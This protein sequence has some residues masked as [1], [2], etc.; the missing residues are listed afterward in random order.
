MQNKTKLI[1]S[2]TLIITIGVVYAKPKLFNFNQSSNSKQSEVI[3]MNKSMYIKQIY[4]YDKNPNT[5][6]YKGNKPS[7]IDFYADWCGPCRRV[8][9]V[10]DEL[11]I[12]YKS[13]VNFFKV[14]VDYERELA[15]I[16]GISNIPV[17]A[18]FPLKGDPQLTVGALQKE[19]YIEL[20]ENL[21]TEKK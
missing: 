2:I 8:A 14:N 9:P 11:S 12:K 13:K 1:L 15:S 4:D 10:M 5:Y 19:K 3:M 16:H 7:V 20:I 21:L 6:I 18:F 17:V